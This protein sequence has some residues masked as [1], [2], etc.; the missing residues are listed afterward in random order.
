ME[1][2]R[3]S[4]EVIAPSI[5]EAIAEGLEDLGV[6]EEAV[7]IEIL[8]I[9]SQGLFGIGSRHARIR[10]TIKDADAQPALSQTRRSGGRQLAITDLWVE[11]GRGERVLSVSSGEEMSLMARYETTMDSPNLRFIVGV[12]DNYH[13]RVLAFDSD[14][15]EDPVKKYPQDGVVACELLWGL[16]LAPG[17]YRLNIAVYAGGALVD[18]LVEAL[19]LEVVEGDFYGGGRMPKI[20]PLFFVPSAWKVE[21]ISR[22]A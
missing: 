15:S 12:Y 2:K 20:M 11:N 9:G 21:R 13:Q 18:H 16:P 3:T 22:T 4:L 7:D 1:E 10:M 19:V 6:P 8:D 5:E 14:I 17:Q